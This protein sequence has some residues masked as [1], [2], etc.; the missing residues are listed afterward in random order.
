MKK[1]RCKV[2]EVNNII[3]EVT[4]YINCTHSSYTKSCVVE[5]L[6][7]GEII[8]IDEKTACGLRAEILDKVDNYDLMVGDEF[9]I[10]Q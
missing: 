2:L 8:N 5:D 4:G 10:K 1:L 9:T 6:E 3:E 7:T